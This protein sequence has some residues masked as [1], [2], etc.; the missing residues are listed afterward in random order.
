DAFSE[1]VNSSG[2]ELGPGLAA[3]IVGVDVTTFAFAASLSAREVDS[4]MHA[5]F[6][7]P[8]CVAALAVHGHL[9]A[10]TFPPAK[11]ADPRVAA[12]AALMDLAADR[13]FSAALPFERPATV[14]IRWRDDSSSSATMRNARGNPDHPLSVDEVLRKCEGNAGATVDPQ[15][16]GSLVRG[17]GS[18]DN[19]TADLA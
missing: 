1:A 13:E 18:G 9:V 2:R 11:L 8:P 7:L 5:R 3:E 12:T 16:A 10:D 19:S 15:I 14:T 4:D 17:G 6:S